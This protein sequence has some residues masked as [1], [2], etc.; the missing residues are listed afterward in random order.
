MSVIEDV[1]KV[2]QDFLAPELR[3]LKARF[4]A[5]EKRAD[6]RHVELSERI[7]QL[8]KRSDERQAEITK[9]AD[10]RHAETM[11]A[12]RASDARMDRRVET[13]VDFTQ[14]RE[15]VAVLEAERQSKQRAA[16]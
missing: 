8:S 9:R 10:E 15:K 16:S 14:I 12:I 3:E 11:D 4:D 6:E 2:L 7:Q 1:R 5:A 13:I